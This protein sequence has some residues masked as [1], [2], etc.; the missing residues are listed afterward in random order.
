[1]ANR[2]GAGGRRQRVSNARKGT[3][4][5]KAGQCR[6][7]DETGRAVP[8]AGRCEVEAEGSVP[9]PWRRVDAANGR[10]AKVTEPERRPDAAAGDRDGAR[11]R[12]RETASSRSPRWRGD[13]NSCQ[14]RPRAGRARAGDVPRRPLRRRRE[15]RARAATPLDD[16]R[17][18]RARAALPSPSRR[19]ADDS[20]DRGGARP[21]HPSPRFSA[22]KRFA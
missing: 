2:K 7:F 21:R 10:D 13:A 8:A 22:A 4:G 14:V 20:L 19:D 9:S 15:R 3:W 12:R 17:S 11:P 6:G 1:M 5:R 18:R 16:G